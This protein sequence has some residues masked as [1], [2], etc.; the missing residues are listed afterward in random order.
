[1]RTATTLGTE[2]LGTPR[3]TAA[4]CSDT[5]LGRAAAAAVGR[6]GGL[7]TDRRVRAR[8]ADARA[9][10]LAVIGDA[11]PVVRTSAAAGRA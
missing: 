8:L 7:A 2:A 1:M 10:E 9:A 4:R 11:E 3:P 5:D 6:C